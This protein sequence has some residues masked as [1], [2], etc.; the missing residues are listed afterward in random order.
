[1]ITLEDLE[2]E[3]ERLTDKNI[4]LRSKNYLTLE[5]KE[6]LKRGSEAAQEI[7]PLLEYAR[8]KEKFN[9]TTIQ[10]HLKELWVYKAQQNKAKPDFLCGAAIL[11]GGKCRRGVGKEGERCYDHR[12]GGLNE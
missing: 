12:T 9:D 1:M 3:Y 4:E 5:E 2:R 6:E 10:G 11:D 7:F 8:L